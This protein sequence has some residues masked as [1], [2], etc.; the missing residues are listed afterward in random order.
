MPLSVKAFFAPASTVS[1][2]WGGTAKAIH[3][4]RAARRSSRGWKY[5]PTGS[6]LSSRWRIPASRPLAIT[7]G[8]P[9]SPAFCAASSL[10]LMPP[11]DTAAD[12]SKT[13]FWMSS[14][15]AS[16]VSRRRAAGS[17]RGSPV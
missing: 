14:V 2:P 16:T 5:V 4:L 9:E 1:R 7:I 17:R 8:I 10:V 3:R 12:A 6:P 15:M 13:I 11:T